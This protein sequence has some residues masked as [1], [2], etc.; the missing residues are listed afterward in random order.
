MKVIFLIA[1]VLIS[2]CLNASQNVAQNLPE[3]PQNTN[4]M[5][6]IASKFFTDLYSA[7][8]EQAI[9]KHLSSD[10]IEHQESAN[11]SK[12]GLKSYI[13][14][15]I[16]K[17]PN[18]QVTIHRVIEENGFVFLH[19]EE[20]LSE[21]ETYVHGE[22]YRLQNSKITEHWSA[23][24]K[25]PK[26]TK[27]GRK[28]FDGQGV[29]LTKTTGV[30]YTQVTRDS[31]LGAFTLPLDEAVS[32]IDQSTTDRYFQ[33][34]PAVGDGKK[35]FMNA[36]KLLKRLGKVGLKTTLDIKMTISEG[37]Y[38]VTLSYFKIPLIYGN[39]VVFD[40]FRLVEDG[41]KDEHWDI[42]E[43]IKGKNISH[44]F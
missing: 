40:L 18:L 15:R 7:K 1:M 19:V 5:K 34:N 28:M 13:K 8:Y 3:S 10:Y 22:L 27:S 31:Y 20:K 25:H 41:R 33:H 21:K 14:K 37:D 43:K 16:H 38:V 2:N 42:A 36:P 26:K 23:V 39:T 35:A 6:S 17:Y 4:H 32:L 30:K 12:E 44:V 24:Q 9:S 29:D 11:F